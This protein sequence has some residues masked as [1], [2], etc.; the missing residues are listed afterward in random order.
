VAAV[1]VP[2]AVNVTATAEVATRFKVAV[3]VT[4]PTPS[5]TLPPN[6]LVVRINA[7]GASPAFDTVANTEPGD[8][9]P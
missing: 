1:A 6:T 8:K 7:E 9:D 2:V 4:L 5:P 3:T